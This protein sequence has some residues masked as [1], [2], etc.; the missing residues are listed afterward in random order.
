MTRYRSYK[1]HELSGPDVAALA[2]QTN[3]AI[4]P[5]GCV[6]MHGPHLP[7]GTDAIQAEGI[8]ELTAE[9]EPAI[10]LP[11]LYF[12][13]NDEMTR[14]P[15]TIA[16][17]PELMARLYEELCC[18]AARNGFTKIVFLISHGG[19]EDVTRFVHHSFLHRRLG[20]RLGFSVFDLWYYAFVDDAEFLDSPRHK[21]GHGGEIETSL[22]LCFRPE[23]VHPERLKP[24]PEGD[25]PYYPKTVAHTWYVIDW[26]RQVPEGYHGEPQLASADK[27]RRLAERAAE[28]CAEVIRQIKAYDPSRDR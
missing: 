6:E 13:I 8:A 25:A 19:S 26:I 10:I 1:W 7:T 18:E 17:S 28:A 14:Y 22:V 2:Q 4:L 9:R 23:L 12:N 27:G 21:Q 15:G 5:I 16:I 20:E 3:V 24:L 11:T